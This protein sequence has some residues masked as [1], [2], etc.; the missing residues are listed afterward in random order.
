MSDP[1]PSP[2]PPSPGAVTHSFPNPLPPAATPAPSTNLNP[3]VAPFHVSASSSH[4]SAELSWMA[5]ASNP[6]SLPRLLK[7][8]KPGPR[9]FEPSR[10]RASWWAP[11][12]RRRRDC[13][14]RGR[15]TVRLLSHPLRRMHVTMDGALSQGRR[16]RRS[17]RC[18]SSMVAKCRQT[19]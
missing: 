8:A 2:P 16:K 14:R 5:R 19:S 1:P 11:G 6:R 15:A 12:G 13:L 9:R 17:H 10:S 18:R 4:H 3:F 7:I